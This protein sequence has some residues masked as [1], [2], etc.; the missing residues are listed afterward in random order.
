[1][2]RI[3]HTSP[4]ILSCLLSGVAGTTFA[5]ESTQAV[6]QAHTPLPPYELPVA[7]PSA[8]DKNRL[9]LHDSTLDWCHTNDVTRTIQWT[10]C[11]SHRRNGTFNLVRSTTKN[12]RNW[13]D[14]TAH[15]LDNWFGE[16]SPEQP[17]SA[18]L[19]VLI[20]SSWDKHNEYEVKPRIRGKIKLPTLENKL[21]VVFGDDSL[22]NELQNNV[23]I[24]NEN[25]ANA[26][27]KTLRQ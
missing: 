6:D 23:A 2:S 21:S 11:T 22:D 20:D 1:M 15:K 17:A 3:K 10:H 9:L 25:P 8:V 24:T 14:K 4:F 7:P 16:P 12:I 19:R 5:Q 13:A 26:A 18:T 27:D